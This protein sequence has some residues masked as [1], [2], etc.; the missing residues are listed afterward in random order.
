M[1]KKVKYNLFDVWFGKGWDNW[2]RMELK[3]GKWQHNNG[4]RKFESGAAN[5]LNIV[6]AKKEPQ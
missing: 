3:Q 6:L 4:D 1:I 2:I 5:L